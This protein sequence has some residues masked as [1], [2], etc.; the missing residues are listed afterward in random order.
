MSALKRLTWYVRGLFPTPT[1]EILLA[2]MWAATYFAVSDIKT[3][4]A[5]Q[6]VAIVEYIFLPVYGM[7]MAAHVFR[8]SRTTAFELSLFEGPAGVYA[9]RMV[10]LF[11]GLLPGVAGV[12]VIT[13]IEGYA[14]FV[15]SILLKLLNYLAIT[16][17]IMAVLDSTA[18]VITFYAVTSAIPMAFSVLLQHPPQGQAWG[19][20]MSAVAYFLSPMTSFHYCQYL[21][22]TPSSG[23]ALSAVVSLVTMGVAYLI[24]GRREFAP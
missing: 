14:Y 11:L 21:Y 15:P 18:A 10:S 16:A 1:T 23:Y 4:G 17:I 22:Y 9:W 8:D 12:A 2:F 5:G 19:P 20:F 24:F 7:L 3:D 6:F 13:S